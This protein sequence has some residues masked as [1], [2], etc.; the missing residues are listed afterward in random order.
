MATRVSRFSKLLGLHGHKFCLC[1]DSQR[2]TTSS[3]PFT[4]GNKDPEC[5]AAPS[6]GDREKERETVKRGWEIRYEGKR[7]A[8]KEGGR[9]KLSPIS[10][11]ERLS[12]QARER[13]RERDE[14]WLVNIG[15]YCRERRGL[16]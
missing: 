5:R 11:R 8:G 13:E 2:L 6:T 7:E 10:T 3:A 16:L 15:W 14:S 1:A 12:E 9:V 4:T